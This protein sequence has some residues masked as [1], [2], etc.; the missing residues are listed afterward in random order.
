M[1]PSLNRGLRKGLRTL[2]QLAVGGAL[3]AAVNVLADGLSAN[4]KV[5]V[6][7]G[8]TVVIAL[9]QNTLEAGGTVPTLLPT[10]AIV[11]SAPAAVAATA[12]AV[13]EMTMKE[14]GD[15][16]SE[17][18]D[19]VSDAAAGVDDTLGGKEGGGAIIAILVAVVGFLVVTFLVADACISDESERNDLGMARTEDNR[20]CEGD[21]ACQGRQKKGCAEAQGPCEDNDNVQLII[22]A[23]PDSCRFEGQP[24]G[25]SA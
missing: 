1:S 23:Q 15:I 7:T 22:C 17:I 10:P 14:T 24:Q 25:G 18:L 3:T 12:G 16:V 21:N 13:V 6:M 19:V 9:A 5:L 4:H 20:P 2:L 8:W 11:T